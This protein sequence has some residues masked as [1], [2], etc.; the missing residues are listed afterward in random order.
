[1]QGSLMDETPLLVRRPIEIVFIYESLKASQLHKGTNRSDGCQSSVAERW[2]RRPEALG[3]TLSSTTFLSCPTTLQSK[4]STDSDGL[5]CVQLD[6]IS[7]DL[8]TRRESYPSDSPGAIML[9][10]PL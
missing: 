5:D 9:V 3:L 7:I 4:G 10:I 6:T 8:Q 1:M 2:R